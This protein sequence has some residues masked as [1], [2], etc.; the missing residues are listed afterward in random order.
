MATAM[1]SNSSAE[2]AGPAFAGSQSKSSLKSNQ[3]DC[4][5]SSSRSAQVKYSNELAQ[6]PPVCHLQPM[7]DMTNMQH[8]P[9][10]AAHVGHPCDTGRQNLQVEPTHL[11][12]PAA[13][14]MASARHKTT[15]CDLS[16]HPY[17]SLA[18]TAATNSHQ[19]QQQQQQQQQQQHLFS[20]L[21][22]NKTIKGKLLF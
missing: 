16:A 2:Q 18:A 5:S 12:A 22:N 4:L 17:P 19:L 15:S 10:G 8:Q 9:I 6:G 3:E 21:I 11:Q 13:I 20:V 1:R 14:L 7:L